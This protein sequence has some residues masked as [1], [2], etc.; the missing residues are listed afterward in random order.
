FDAYFTSRTLE[1]NRRNV[2][3]AEYW[4]ENFNCKL[5]ISGS[6][7][8]D[9]DRKCTGQER[10]G[11]DSNYEQEGKVQFVIDA[12]YAM[13]HALHHMNKDLCADYRGVCPEMEQAGGKKLLK[14]IRNVNF[15]GSAGT[16]VMF[17]KNGDAPG[18]Y[19]IFQYQTTNTTN[20]GYRLIGQW[21]DEL[22]LNRTQVQ[23]P[24][25]RSPGSQLP[26][27]PTAEEPSSSSCLHIYYTQTLA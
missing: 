22:Q 2:W 12:V 25:L 15:N 18:R 26:V 9:T 4:E 27:T 11:K 17:N 8:E 7:K 19:D 20:P 13:A 10:I 6:K 1:N 3:F 5:T 16:P 23:F 24:A 14:Y 21:T